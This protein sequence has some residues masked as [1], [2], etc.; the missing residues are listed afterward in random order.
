MRIAGEP[1]AG[2]SAPEVCVR[3]QRVAASPPATG[4]LSVVS[5]K[6]GCLTTASI[7]IRQNGDT[8]RAGDLIAPAFTCP[9]RAIAN[10][11]DALHPRSTTQITWDKQTH[12][13]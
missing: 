13:I 12:H 5:Y 10:W 3:P 2:G 7:G 8:L 11:Y 1:V 9:S 4:T 6:Q